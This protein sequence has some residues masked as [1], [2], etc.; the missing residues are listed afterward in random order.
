MGRTRTI[1]SKMPLAR[2][3][4]RDVALCEAHRTVLRWCCRIGTTAAPRK[5][6]GVSDGSRSAVR[7]R[8]GVLDFFACFGTPDSRTPAESRSR[9]GDPCPAE[10]GAN[11]TASDLW[12]P[13]RHSLLSGTLPS[14]LSPAWSSIQINAAVLGKSSQVKNV[15][16]AKRHLIHSTDQ[17]DA[18]PITSETTLHGRSRVGRARRRGSRARAVLASH[19]D[20][21]YTAQV[22]VLH[23]DL[24]STTCTTARRQSQWEGQ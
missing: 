7:P 10:R 5:R 4:T 1:H 19:G 9:F 17:A 11:P 15:S 20:T 16:F 6:V 23:V 13:A 8:V 14:S 2:L 18:I 24:T 3:A 22:R 21:R 12:R